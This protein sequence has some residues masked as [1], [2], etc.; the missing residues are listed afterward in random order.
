AA[1]TTQGYITRDDFDQET[2]S[3]TTSC[4]WSERSDVLTVSLSTAGGISIPR[5]LQNASTGS[6]PLSPLRV[7]N[8]IGIT[9]FG[10]MVPTSSAISE[11]DSSGPPPAGTNRMSI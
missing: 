7:W 11:G 3:I 1:Y 5:C 2:G 8:C 10:E 6:R 4:I 9:I